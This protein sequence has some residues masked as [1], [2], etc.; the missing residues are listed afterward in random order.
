MYIHDHPDCRLQSVSARLSSA[1]W[2]EYGGFPIFIFISIDL[3]LS[4]G[5]LCH[6]TFCCMRI[7]QDGE[8]DELTSRVED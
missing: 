3:S 7:S 5:I 4:Y 8:I 6:T 1:L 2:V